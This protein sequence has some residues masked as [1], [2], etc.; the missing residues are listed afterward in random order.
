MRRSTY[1]V[2]SPWGALFL[3]WVCSPTNFGDCWLLDWSTI[4]FQYCNYLQE[5]TPF[6]VWHGQSSNA[7][8]HLQKLAQWC[9]C[10]WC[11]IHQE[12]H[13][14]GRN[15]NE[16]KWWCNYIPWAFEL[17][18]SKLIRFR[19]ILILVF[20]ASFDSLLF[21]SLMVVFTKIDVINLLILIVI[22]LWNDVWNKDL[23]LRP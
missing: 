3:C 10:W 7:Y 11:S 17:D 2:E 5:L 18:E 13:G 15:L 1:M 16:W 21:S 6:L 12:I 22:G 14:N 19:W 4:F 20:F 9:S 23:I 8:K